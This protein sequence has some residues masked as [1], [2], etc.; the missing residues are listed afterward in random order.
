MTLVINYT[1]QD[2]YIRWLANKKGVTLKQM[3]TDLGIPYQS[4]KSG[5][6]HRKMRTKRQHKIMDY[7]DGDNQ[8]FES[9][10]RKFSYYN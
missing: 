7:L 4:F 10:P 6:L 9:L 5:Y 2:E 8:I 1:T 3:C